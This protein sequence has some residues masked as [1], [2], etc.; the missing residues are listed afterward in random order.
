MTLGNLLW[1][2]LVSFSVCWGRV[3]D[4]QVNQNDVWISHSCHLMSPTRC[5]VSPSFSF[6]KLFMETA[7]S[8]SMSSPPFTLPRS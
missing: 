7:R 5:L 2:V 4:V 1:M 6:R 3:A 8:R